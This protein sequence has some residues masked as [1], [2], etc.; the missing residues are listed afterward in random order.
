M[1]CELI[2][3]RIVEHDKS[4]ARIFQTHRITIS[5]KLMQ[6][7]RYKT[8]C[9]LLS[10]PA[11]R[12]HVAFLYLVGSARVPRPSQVACYDPPSQVNV[13]IHNSYAPLYGAY[14]RLDG[15]ALFSVTYQSVTIR[16]LYSAQVLDDCSPLFCRPPFHPAVGRQ[17][18]PRPRSLPADFLV[19]FSHNCNAATPQPPPKPYSPS[20][21]PSPR[22]PVV[23]PVL[24]T[25]DVQILEVCPLHLRAFPF[26]HLP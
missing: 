3:E 12:T 15:F 4:S 19:A 17:A 16:I 21:S 25:Q 8:I 14:P 7:Y 1:L 5:S 20:L 2:V 22:M 10:P 26:G 23:A 24:G 18:V 6:T 11:T 9:L 13:P